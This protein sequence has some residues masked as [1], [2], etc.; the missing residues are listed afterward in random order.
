MSKL[1]TARTQQ[2]LQ[3]AQQQAD[4]LQVNACIAIVDAGAHLKAFLRM[5][6][7]ALGPVD[8]CQRKARTSALFQCE[9]GDFGEVIERDR[10][11]GMKDSNGGLA[12]FH[13]GVPIREGGQV[14]GAIGVSGGSAEQD[15]IIARYALAQENSA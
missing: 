14:I 10:L 11:I 3:R 12:T 2:I 15:R 6:G 8:V 13:G 9:S 1:S 5:D 7:A 4:E